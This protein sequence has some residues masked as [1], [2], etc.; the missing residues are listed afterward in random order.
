MTSYFI[1]IWLVTISNFNSLAYAQQAGSASAVQ[2]PNTLEM[3][4]I[5]VSFLL[6]MYVVF[7]RPQ[8][9]KFKEQKQFLD[10]LAVG[11]EVITSG[12]LIGRIKSIKDTIVLL[13]GGCGT[14][15]V[16]KS[17]INPK[18][19]DVQ[20]RQK[21]TQKKQPKALSAKSSSL[22]KGES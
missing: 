13:D 22:Q 3:L 19:P 9:K 1:L 15:K 6:L 14:L 8:A 17:S 4:V 18:A 12:G 7:I 16:L 5:P 11:D 2:G 10:E 21:N 20:N